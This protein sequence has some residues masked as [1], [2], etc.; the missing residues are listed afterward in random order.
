MAFLF[1]PPWAS[2]GLPGLW[3][4]SPDLRESGL[5]LAETNFWP[6]IFSRTAKS[7]IWGF[8]PLDLLR[9]VSKTSQKDPPPNSTSPGINSVSNGALGP[10]LWPNYWIWS[11]AWVKSLN[12]DVSKQTRKCHIYIYIYIYIYMRGAINLPYLG[13]TFLRNTI[14]NVNHCG[15]LVMEGFSLPGLA[16]AGPGQAWPGQAWAG[17]ARPCRAGPDKRPENAGRGRPPRKSTF[18]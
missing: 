14:K 5:D 16:W 8:Y 15:N 13:R 4:N 12:L 2:P 3:F 7:N 9:M 11:W 18:Y 17:Q 6:K 1:G 10:I